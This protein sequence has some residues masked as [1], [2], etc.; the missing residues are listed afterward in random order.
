MLLDWATPALV[1]WFVVLILPWRPWSTRERL[2]ADAPR[3][4]ER[5][6]DITVLI[7]ARNEAHTLARTLASLADQGPGL[8]IL[9][10]DDQSNDATAEVA[11]RS[12]VAGVRVVSGSALPEGWVGKVWAQSQARP[13][14][15]RPLV[16]L[17]D[18]DIAVAPGLVATLRHRL[19]GQGQGERLGLASL[20]AKLPM[21]DFWGR[22]LLPAFVYFFKLIYPFHLANANNKRVAAAAGGCVLL[23]LKVL[24]A[25][26]G[27]ASLRDAIID[28]CTLAR[29]V[30][31]AGYRTWIGLTHS[32]SSHRPYEGLGDIWRMV[33]RTAFTQL[34]YSWLLLGL[35]TLLMVVCLLSPVILA[36]SPD[37]PTRV[38]ALGSWLLMASLYL[39]T[40]RFYRLPPWWSL[41]LPFSGLL[42]LIM[43]W[44]SARRFLLGERSAWRGRQY[45]AQRLRTSR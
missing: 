12:G 19:R 5:L 33:A 24:D 22:F 41:L 3:E 15:E 29:A 9:V 10:V 16:L 44:D 27:L 35:C 42:F 23:E 31:N 18:A 17:L 37:L 7:P 4:H 14:L 2:E 36:F 38:T 6:D 43:T 1:A 8:D 32:V 30:K 34:R 45:S 21:E 13:Y 11:R 40:L 28:D 26:G 25:I 20:M 39:P